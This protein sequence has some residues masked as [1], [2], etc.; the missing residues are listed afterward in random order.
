MGTWKSDAAWVGLDAG[1]GGGGGLADGTWQVDT[2]DTVLVLGTTTGTPAE[3]EISGLTVGNGTHLV[4]A[5]FSGDTDAWEIDR[6]TRNGVDDVLDTAFQ[7]SGG[8]EFPLAVDEPASGDPSTMT[9]KIRFRP[10]Y[11]DGT[12]KSMTVQLYD[13]AGTLVKTLTASH[14]FSDFLAGKAAEFGGFIEG[15]SMEQLANGTINNT[16]T[17]ATAA[18]GTEADLTA[19]MAGAFDGDWSIESA[20][21]PGV[22]TGPLAKYLRALNYGGTGATDQAYASL[23]ALSAN[24]Q[25][26][27]GLFR[28]PT[29]LTNNGEGRSLWRFDSGVN[30]GLISGG[31]MVG[32]E[33]NGDYR[34][35]MM[36]GRGGFSDGNQIHNFTT[37]ST[38][39]VW[40]AAVLRRVP[41]GDDQ[42]VAWVPATGGNLSAANNGESTETGFAWTAAALTHL[43]LLTM[44]DVG[45]KADDIDLGPFYLWDKD[46]TDAQVN[47]FLDL[48]ANGP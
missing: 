44:A 32:I 48:I 2:A 26:I 33:N 42:K 17:V 21:P 40:Y 23:G 6:V 1:G 34:G 10:L 16:D 20:T 15:W 41:I 4:R 13:G 46:L 19:T 39:T 7:P 18:T 8:Q 27:I 14:T 22:G 47:E 9:C 29:T 12:A 38:D 24:P 5:V 25:T 30:A 28:T 35:G 3:V 43:S 31:A 45:A 11:T 36:V 37:P